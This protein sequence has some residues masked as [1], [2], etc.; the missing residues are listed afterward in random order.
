MFKYEDI[1]RR[2]DRHWVFCLFFKRPISELPFVSVPKQ[3]FV[4]NHS[5]V[6]SSYGIFNL[7]NSPEKSFAQGLILKQRQRATQR[8]TTDLLI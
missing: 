6:N 7:F 3:V 1:S 4:Q 2:N 5:D 8:W